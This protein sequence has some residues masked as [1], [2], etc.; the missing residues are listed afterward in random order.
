MMGNPH[1]P[2][3]QTR[4]VRQTRSMMGMIA[5]RRPETVKTRE[6]KRREIP[7]GVW[8][9]TMENRAQV[10]EVGKRRN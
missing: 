9:R 5:Q 8:K 2:H 10:I 3:R 6:N 4:G 1:Q 7:K